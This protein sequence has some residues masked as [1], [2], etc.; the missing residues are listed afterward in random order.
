MWEVTMADSMAA[1]FTVE[2]DSTAAEDSMAVLVDIM[3]AIEGA[4][5]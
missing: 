4:R 5:R 2:A 3:V 1:G